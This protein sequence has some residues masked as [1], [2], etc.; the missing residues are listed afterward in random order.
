[1]TALVIATCTDSGLD[2]ASLELVSAAVTI[3]DTVVLGVIGPDADRAASISIA[4]VERLLAVRIQNP[5]PGPEMLQRAVDALIEK[6]SPRCVLMPFDRQMSSFA[7]GLAERRDAA[8]I[9]DVVALHRE[10]DGRV[11]AAR[12]IYAEK[13]LA[14]FAVASGSLAVLLLR[15]GV[16]QMPA[17][18]SS[19]QHPEV[20]TLNEHA[21]E[22]IRCIEELPSGQNADELQHAEVV[23]AV[24]RGIATAENVALVA[25]AARKLGAEIAASRPVVDV[26]LL[27][28]SRQVG[29]SGTNVKPRVYVALGISGAVQHLIGIG[30][31]TT[32]VAV[33]TDENAAIFDAAQLGATVDAIEVIKQLIEDRE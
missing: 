22:R 15:G 21:T 13:A 18:H 16:W 27:P 1:M 14:R 33:N 12:P 23:F 6:T 4:G 29:Q 10:T 2:S 11:I 9:T 28:K 5:R 20:V 3:A 32:I 25:S 31:T 24:G 30:S 7:S 26:G 19:G 17:L 8:C